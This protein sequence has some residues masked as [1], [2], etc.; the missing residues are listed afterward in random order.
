MREHA[1]LAHRNLQLAF[2][3]QRT[4]D[5]VPGALPGGYGAYGND[6][7]HYNDSI[8]G[9]GVNFAV[10][11]TI[12]SALR[13]I[14][15]HLPV[16]ATLQLPEQYVVGLDLLR[17]GLE[18]ANVAG[19]AQDGKVISVRL[20]LFAEMMKG[21]AWTP[22]TLKAVGGTEGVGITFLEETFSSASA[23]PTTTPASN[24][25]THPATQPSVSRP[26]RPIGVPAARPGC[27]ETLRWRG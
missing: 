25:P 1:R 15:D 11:L 2:R 22:S 20:A 5:L 3:N 23:P 19:L 12:A 26:P 21:K 16:V 27:T 24:R 7:L 18:V 13:Q 9:G 6:G 4:R 10:S 8:D 17:N 14:S